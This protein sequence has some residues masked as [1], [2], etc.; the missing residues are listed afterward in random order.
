[1]EIGTVFTIH[2]YVATTDG[3]S[4]VGV[5]EQRIKREHGSTVIVSEQ[6]SD[7]WPNNAKGTRAAMAWTLSLNRAEAERNNLHTTLMAKAN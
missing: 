7:T 6:T 1:M 5:R 4:I 3:K 2:G